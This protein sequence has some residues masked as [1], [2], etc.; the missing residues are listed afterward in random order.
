MP[1]L[2]KQSLQHV[3]FGAPVPGQSWTSQPKN[4][5]WEQ[6]PQFVKLKDAMNFLM[7]QLTDF[8]HQKGLFHMFEMKMPIEAITRT[9]LFGG[10]TQGKW[11]VDLAL[12]MYK[13]LMM[14]LIAMAHRAGYKDIPVLMP[15]AVQKRKSEDLNMY[16][17][18]DFANSKPSDTKAQPQEITQEQPSAGFMRRQ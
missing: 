3:A 5:R 17:F 13:P 4:A 18:L 6:P 14:T 10:F 7:S 15:K 8:T 1:D 2:S 11:T 12:L 16:N 9:I